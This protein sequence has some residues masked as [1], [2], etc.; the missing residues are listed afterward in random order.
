MGRSL[1][2]GIIGA[3]NM[4]HR[5]ARAYAF[6]APRTRLVATCDV[7]SDA[8]ARLAESFGC[9]TAANVEALLARPDVDAVS[10]CTPEPVHLEPLLKAAASRRHILIE[11]PM[12]VSMAEAR[13]MKQA[14][15][16][17]GVKLMVGHLFRFDR[18]CVA[19]RSALDAG[20][21]G[22][23]RSIDCRFHGTPA[24]QDRIRDFELSLIVFRGCHAIDLMRWYSE[25]EVV[26]GYAED[27]QGAMRARGYHS[28]DAVFCLMRFANGTVGSLEVNAHVPP[29]HPSAGRSEMVLIGEEG[30]L[31]IDLGRPWLTIAGGEAFEHGSGDQK[32]LWFREQIDAFA[33]YVLDD[34]PCLATADDAIAALRVAVAAVESART[35]APVAVEGA[36]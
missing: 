35:H 34:A 17:A 24:Q 22:R 23:L 27:L 31:E 15:E 20:R 3:G 14:V 26:R 6:H 33:R 12:A 7:R 16:A 30:M 18:R 36:S 2:V 25:S 8:A 5:H 11:K 1:G 32:D 4:G 9:D 28:E 19:V 29:T 13:R 21:I 10:I